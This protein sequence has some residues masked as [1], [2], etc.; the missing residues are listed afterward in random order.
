MSEAQY[1]QH[2]KQV[3]LQRKVQLT[4]STLDAI[5]HK[6]EE[7]LIDKRRAYQA[8]DRA[9]CRLLKFRESGGAA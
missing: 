1:V 5:A 2:K 9:F 3:V 4:K 7:T 8:Y 6:I